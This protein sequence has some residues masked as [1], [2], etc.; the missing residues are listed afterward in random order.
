MNLYLID[1][2]SYVYRAYYAI[3]E[4][5]NSKGFPTN[6][7]YGFTNMLLKIIREKKP[8]GIVVSF[9]TPVPTERHR[10]YEE[11]KAQRPETPRELVE[12]MP[13]IKKMISAFNISIFEAP[14]YEA[15]DLLGTIAKRA[16][17]EG[18][19]VFI[20]TGDK[21]MLQLVNNR[22]KIYDPMKDKVL[23]EEF[24]K[25]KFGVGPE[26]ITEF[27]ALA[28]D[29]V[30]NIPGIKG[31]GEKTAK[32][33]LSE[34]ESLDDLLNNTSRIR[35][36]KLRLLVSEN[37]DIVRLSKKLATI[38]TSV[39]L[40]I[41]PEFISGEEFRLKEPDWASLLPLFREFEF[42]SLM[43]LIPSGI[44]SKVS[45]ETVFS[46]ERVKEIAALIKEKFAFDIEASASGGSRNPLTKS[47]V[48]LAL[49]IE[50][51]H[52]FY[53]PVSHSYS[54]IPE[55]I[56]K[57]D[58]LGVL[59]RIFEDEQI[60]K[61]GHNLK[62]GIMILKE[63]GINVKG[64]LFDT[65]IASYLINPNK[66]NHSLEEVSMEYLSYRKKTFTE[67]LGKK[68]SFSEV[69]LKEA[70]SY[71][72]ENAGL[73][74]E[75]KEVLFNT[76]RENNLEDIYLNI[77]MPLIY[78]LADM[79]EAGV[80]VDSNKL[81]GIS[82]ELERE[83]DGI[84]RR[85]YFLAGE[86][87]NINSP[88]QL[89]RVLFHSLGFQPGKKKKT[90][91]STEM[92]VLEELA[93]SHELPREILNFRSLNKLKTTYIDVLPKL[94]NP[95]TGR[96]HTSFN[97]TATATGRLSS[98]DPNL[99]NIPIRGEW[100][101]RIRETFIAEGDNL[102]L[103]AD[104]SQVELRILA[105]LS[106]DEGLINAFKNNLDIHARTASEIFGIPIDKVTPDI[107]RIAKTVN[108]GVIYGISPFGLSET[109]S[110]SRDEAKK[111]IEQYFNRHPGVKSY[112]EKTLEEAR[113]KGY[114]ST[115]FGRRRA[116][117]GIKSKNSN[118]RQQ[119]E[120]LAI[121]SPIQGTAADIIKIAMI[122]IWKRFKDRDLKT[123]MILQV[124][125][126]LLFELP[127][128]EF[129]TVKDIVKKKMEGVITLSVPVS[130]D[131]NYG[132]NWV[133]AHPPV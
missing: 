9:D 127:A 83:L 49:C 124:H 122:N 8:D 52:A 62:Y 131:I 123:R 25:E 50:K 117:P 13:Y 31:V 5:T 38:D 88:K 104:Y 4:L 48:G 81:E 119:G 110:I 23:D 12:Q 133:E 97:Q 34:F 69:S 82:K 70:T 99:Q 109:L 78:V 67:V 65:M 29:A 76:L 47:L 17:S 118:I 46:I 22:V 96:I 101:R 68:S 20:V 41:N 105:H 74:L 15:D 28:G 53:I 132:K 94:I 95:K 77:E 30:D 56:N 45:Y 129:S 27:M 128:E 100:G 92:G 130:V 89:S 102:L 35:K 61:I 98:S 115:L 11:Y 39:P 80:K 86:E 55:Q 126:E 90:G 75:L 51:G 60:A 1:G 113:D 121:N 36:D 84:Q 103:S 64:P 111:Y 85:I 32:E 112:M 33:L 106:N 58:V 21:D 6:A 108:F 7:I 59:T 16:A 87:F 71:A 18:I 91:F 19:D 3:R 93:E 114:V 42:G 40:D 54:G 125:D 73:S 107:R 37:A 120:R 79:E 72:S 116:V 10:I 14:G 63:D 43:K 2:N 66:P 26:R 44:S 24:V 57:K